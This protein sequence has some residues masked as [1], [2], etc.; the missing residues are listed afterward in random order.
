M[1]AVGLYKYLPIDHE[2][3]LIDINIKKP[4]ARGRD[5]LVEIKAISVNPVDTKVRSPKNVEETDPKIL[6]WDATGVVVE[7]GEECTLF[8]P[9]DEVFYSGSLNRPGTYSE[10]HLVD[11]RIVG[12]KPQTLNFAEAAAMPLTSITA[13]E[14]LFERLGIDTTNKNEN[15]S[16]TILIIGGAG[17]VGSIAIQLAKWAGLQV[18]AT[19]SR[20]ETVMWVKDCGADFVINHYGSLKDQLVNLQIKNVDYILC[21]NDTDQHWNAMGEVIKPQGKICSIVDNKYPIELNTLKSK[22]VTFVWEFMFTKAMFET[23]DM[24]SQHHILNKVSKLID[25]GM[26]KTTLKETLTPIHAE[27]LRKAH[28]MLES[29]KTIGKIVLESFK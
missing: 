29:G 6:G 14:A 22:S 4:S 13:W 8:Q 24:I 23:E 10:Y 27:N 21:S 19:A 17:G 20:E 2:D 1:K 9:G 3:S 12:K 28:R 16:K 11:E 26:L 15:R 25:E 18:V 5:L 7:V